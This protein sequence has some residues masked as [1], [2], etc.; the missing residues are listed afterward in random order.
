[1]IFQKKRAAHTEKLTNSVKLTRLRVLTCLAAAGLGMSVLAVSNGA[2]TAAAL[3]AEPTVEACVLTV[4][5]ERAVAVRTREQAQIIIDTILRRASG[6]DTEV[7]AF[8]RTVGIEICEIPESRVADVAD[9]L[10]YMDP[11]EG[12]MPMDLAVLTQETV[13]ETEA[14]PCTTVTV[15]VEDGYSDE[16]EV[17]QEGRDGEQIKTYSVLCRD[18]KPV[19]KTL[20]TAVVTREPVDRIVAQGV[21]PG[22]R[23]DSRGFYIWPANGVISSGFG[24]RNISVG[25]KNHQGV[26]IANAEGSQVVAADGGD[27]IYAEFNAGGYGNLIRIRHD[28]GSVTCYAHLRKILVSAGDRVCQGQPIGEMGSTGKVT[29]PHLHFEIR[30][31]GSTPV[32]PTPYM[33]GLLQ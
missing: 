6:P 21:L 32:D 26:D 29:G 7:A 2:V 20:K 18:G 11:A 23:T 10:N 31:D 4:D 25:S 8:S 17:R 1:M 22:S 13:R 33:T 19:L 28:N 9:A 24:G 15:P 30:P 12:P 27:V 14:V 16:A 5:G 3:Y